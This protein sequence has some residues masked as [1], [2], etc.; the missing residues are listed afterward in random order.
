[1]PTMLITGGSGFVGTN[2]VDHA[3]DTGWTVSSLDIAEPTL[4]RHRPFWSEVDLL[5][6]EAVREAVATARPD[7]VVH[8]GA[9][10]DLDGADVADYELNVAGTRNLVEALSAVEGLHSRLVNVSTMLVCAYGRQPSDSEDVDPATA[11]G[12]S[13][14]EAE[15]IVAGSKGIDWV[16]IRPTSVWGP[17]FSGGYKQFFDRVLSRRYVNVG[18]KP[19]RKDFVYVGNLV[20]DIVDVAAADSVLVHTK[21]FY[22]LDDPGYST[23]EFAEV[24]AAVAGRNAPRSL[25]LWLW[26]L[27]AAGFDAAKTIRVLSDPPMTRFRLSNMTTPCELDTWGIDAVTSTP[28]VDL[29]SGVEATVDWIAGR[30][31]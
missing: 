21:T 24:I 4:E 31:E 11:Y 19:I 16:T 28:R 3:L 20:A 7:V 17:H 30:G 1:M 23:R 25:P 14:L 8:L 6:E 9:R 12:Q 2:L 10:T 13:K 27:V 29:R 22:S 15:R 18:M 5:E 26:K